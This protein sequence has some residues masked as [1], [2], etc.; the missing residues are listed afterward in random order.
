MSFWT[1]KRH[2]RLVIACSSPGVGARF[3][4]QS[5]L[6]PVLGVGYRNYVRMFP[7]DRESGTFKADIYLLRGKM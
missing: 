3:V 1:T 2:G 4:W 7:L 6:R 5:R